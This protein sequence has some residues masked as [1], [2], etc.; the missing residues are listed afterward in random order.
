MYLNISISNE[1]LRKNYIKIEWK[2]KKNKLY[3]THV[4]VIKMHMLK[5]INIHPIW[6][7]IHMK[8]LRVWSDW[9]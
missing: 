2:V 6:N 1:K 9:A 5:M 8:W 3:K 7:V 4:I